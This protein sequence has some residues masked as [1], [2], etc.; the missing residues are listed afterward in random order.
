[1]NTKVVKRG[2]L[3]VKIYRSNYGRQLDK[4]LGYTPPAINHRRRAKGYTVHL[5]DWVKP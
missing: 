5:T 1:M 2:K 4:F 3:H